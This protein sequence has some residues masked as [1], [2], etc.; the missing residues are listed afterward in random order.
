[1]K[2]RYAAVIAA[3]GTMGMPMPLDVQLKMMKEA[4]RQQ[5]QDS[6]DF[7]VF[8]LFVDSSKAMWDVASRAHMLA[9]AL[10]GRKKACFWML[11][12][13]EWRDT[14]D[15]DFACYVERNALFGAMRA[16]EIAGLR[17][18]FPHPADQFEVITSKSWMATLSVHPGAHLPAA[19]LEIGRAH[20]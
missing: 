14:G 10:R 1:M 16:C 6:H 8:Q 20:V 17:S 9:K 13:A 4:N 3:K 5:N 7:E 11:W 15:P 12:P 19:I 2:L 18:A